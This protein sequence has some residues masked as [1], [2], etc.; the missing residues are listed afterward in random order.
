[1]TLTGPVLQG[2][3]RAR[4]D[5]RA[6]L[7]VQQATSTPVH[8]GAARLLGALGEHA[9]A[10]L[11]LGTAG[12]VVDRPQR[13]RWLAATAAVLGAHGASVVLKRVSRRPRPQHPD[14]LV[15]VPVGRWS[16][17]SSHVAST[18]AA[19]LLY[20]RLIG[21]P[22]ASALVPLMAVSRM[23]LGVHTPLDVL[24]GAAVGAAAASAHDR[25]SPQVARA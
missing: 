25:W 8:L 15:H 12:A 7:V 4:A 3:V 19:A 13:A 21:R 11:V 24:A 1:M 2:P 23:A 22:A 9:A 18:T 5:L 17:P 16:L 20:G 14:L 6:L 10:W